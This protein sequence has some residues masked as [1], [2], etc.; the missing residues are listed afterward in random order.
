M[1]IEGELKEAKEDLVDSI[2]GLDKHLDLEPPG[3]QEK[4][5]PQYEEGG[6]GQ[7]GNEKIDGQSIGDKREAVTDTDTENR[8]EGNG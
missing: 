8:E 7:G 3:S 2:S 1:N 4:E 5:K 6:E